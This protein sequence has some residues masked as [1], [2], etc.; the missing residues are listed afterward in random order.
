MPIPAINSTII[1][2]II[3]RPGPKGSQPPM[4][5]YRHIARTANQ[6]LQVLFPAI[7]L[8]GQGI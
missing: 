7:S 6:Q 5:R 1:I 8:A 3:P 2:E 4:P